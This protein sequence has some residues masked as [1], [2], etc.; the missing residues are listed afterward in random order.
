M[1]VFAY[2]GQSI[3]LRCASNA[4]SKFTRIQHI[5]PNGTVE[6]LLSNDYLNT[7]YL[8]S[9]IRI[10]KIKSVYVIRIDPIMPHSGGVYSCQDDVSHQNR[11][12]HTT[13]MTINVIRNQSLRLFN[14]QS[15][16]SFT[17]LQYL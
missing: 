1:N 7:K 17:F 9:E 5:L 12:H 15:I 16:G 13:N 14:F 3:E 10:D 2:L 6:T 11:T 4:S 8:A